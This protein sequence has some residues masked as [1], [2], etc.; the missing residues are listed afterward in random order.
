MTIA[1][2][3]TSILLTLLFRF[4]VENTRFEQKVDQASAIVLERQRLVEK[5]ETILTSL[6]PLEN[7][8]TVFY[9]AFFPDDTTTESLVFSFNA[10]I[11]PNPEYSHI[12]TGRIYLT[13]QGE[14]R[15]TYWTPDK[16]GHRTE[17]LLQNIQDLEWQF[18]G[19]KTDK[20]PKVPVLASNWGWLKQ[21]PKKRGGSPEIIRLRLWCE[22]NKKKHP[23]PNLQLAFIMPVLTPIQ[24]TK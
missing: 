14:L 3:L 10:G 24:V 1:I 7:E 19:Q 23:E 5:L 11:D 12:L 21:W 2:A 16:K 20:D 13:E 22:I 15:L 17:V 4:L 6:Q 18:L 8:N 9:T